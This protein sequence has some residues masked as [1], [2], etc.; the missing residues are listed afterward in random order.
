MRTLF[1]IL[2]FT[3]LS[4]TNIFA[5]NLDWAKLVQGSANDCGASIAE[6]GNSN[7]YTAGY[8]S[9]SADFDPNAGIL[10]LTSAGTTDV[11]ISKTDNNGS[12]IWVKQIGGTGDDVATS[13]AIDASG[14]IYV[15]GYFSGTVDFDPNASVTSLT[16]AGNNDIFILKLDASG[17]FIWVKKMGST[18][19]DRA[20][21]VSSD[22]SNNIYLTGMFTNTV[23]FDPNAGTTNLTSSG[24]FDVF[25]LKLSD[26][27]NLI[28][29]KKM[30]GSSADVAYSIIT[31]ATGNVYTTGEFQGG[32]A[33]FD[34]GPG[35]AIITST[36]TGVFVSKLD[37]SGNFA[38]AKAFSEAGGAGKALRIDAS[39]N[40][41][42]AGYFSGTTDFDAGAGAFNVTADFY[43][44]FITKLNS[45]GN[46]VWA[47]IMGGYGADFAFALEID[48]SGNLYTT[49]NFQD[50]TVADFD[51][52][53]SVYTFSTTGSGAFISKLDTAGN[54]VSAKG[55]IGGSNGTEGQGIDVD[56]SYNIYLTGRLMQTADFDPNSDTTNLTS[57]N[58]S[59]DIFIVKLSQCTIP[60][61]PGAISGNTSVT[62]GSNQTYGVAPVAGATSYLWSIPSGWVGTSTTNTISVTTNS[63]SGVISVIAQN[64]CGASPAAVLSVNIAA[65]TCS[66][67]TQNWSWVQSSGQQYAAN[68]VFD[69]ATDNTGNTYITGAF[70]S[71]TLAFGSNVLTNTGGADLFLTKYDNTG[72]VLWT[73]SAV[74]NSSS[75]E[76]SWAVAVDENNNVVIT[77]VFSGTNLT[78][79]GTTLSCPNNGK[80]IFIVKYDSQGNLMWAKSVDF[81]STIWMTDIT[82]DNN[83]NIFIT[84]QYSSATNGITFGSIT[85]NAPSNGNPFVAKYDPNGN[86]VW[87]KAATSTSGNWSEGIAVD[88]SGNVFI[89]G[90]YIS[91]SSDPFSFGGITLPNTNGTRNIFTMKFNSN[92]NAIWAKNGVPAT[93]NTYGDNG[94]GIDVDQ[95]GNVAVIGSMKSNSITFGTIPVT[96]SNTNNTPDIVII[97]YDGNGNTLWAKQAG[98]LGYDEGQ[99]LAFDKDGNIYVTGYFES[100]PA[101]FENITITK[102]NNYTPSFFVSKYDSNGNVMWVKYSDKTNAHNGNQKTSGV[103]LDACGN[104]FVA[105][106]ADNN[107]VFDNITLSTGGVFTAKLGEASVGFNE[108]KTEAEMFQIFPNPTTG[109]FHLTGNKQFLDGTIRV[110]NIHGQSIFESQ[111]FVDEIN[112]ANQPKGIYLLHLYS[113]NGLFVKKIIIQ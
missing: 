7:V 106:S 72:N 1:K 47:K 97:K 90:G 76:E 4:T 26:I 39:N 58:N 15:T 100:K 95:N 48:G 65:V 101:S 82:T 86:V 112:L 110:S 3:T 37:A 80:N 27:G 89:T 105:A 31:D 8:F 22:M 84:G 29:A 104:V 60:G 23:D 63:L 41:Y 108:F 69:L 85:L 54:F 9:S 92:G 102:A 74:G 77:G 61:Q 107:A 71:P 59:N 88:G 6:D 67:S 43:D 103:D 20:L 16:S 55:I 44:I 2:L 34:P 68:Y 19:T 93:T 81:T 36:I 109:I 53:P 21:A 62:S 42:I 28:W 5:Q 56:N 64:T 113:K 70:N 24:S 91:S 40:L 98:G 38:W 11:F 111:Q 57:L 66:V 10:T 78:F 46:F 17:N 32:A 51:P 18:N 25:V 73:R 35:T 49:G 13:L 83:G 99:K 14:Y 30:G 50:G 79:G 96:N 87:A 52:G 45:S 94:F 12:L 75:F 33:D